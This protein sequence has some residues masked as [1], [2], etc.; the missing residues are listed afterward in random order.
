M[1]V[2]L[3]PVLLLLCARLASAAAKAPDLYPDFYFMTLTHD[4]T[5][6]YSISVKDRLAEITIMAPHGGTIEPG[7]SEMA[8]E[9]A[10]S[11]WNYYAFK[12]LLPDN[13]RTMHVTSK[14][15]NDQIAVSL[16][17]ASLI[18][19]TLH[20]H[21]ELTE[22][23]CVGGY[24]KGLRLAVVDHLQK[25]G[26]VSEHPCMR[27][28]GAA[29]KNIANHAVL[30][31]LQLEIATSLA[32]K[33]NSDAALRGKFIAAVRNAITESLPKLRRK[34]KEL[35]GRHVCDDRSLWEPPFP[36]RYTP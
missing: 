36:Y 18:T 23:V 29:C 22:S 10:G 12:N 15:Y 33:L 30:G 13:G 20:R 4:T 7:T 2:R 24:N 28:P 5:K 27:L 17:S 11:D 14:N 8:E 9:L 19:V 16:S 21:K 35:N 1:L 26:F 34:A 25:A 6:E 32:T 3:T 31:G